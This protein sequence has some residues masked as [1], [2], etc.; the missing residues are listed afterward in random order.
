ME[1]IPFLLIISFCFMFN[2]LLVLYFA[3]IQTVNP[4]VNNDEILLSIISSKYPLRNCAALFH[5]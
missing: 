1:T 4:M 3:R 2:F 5:K